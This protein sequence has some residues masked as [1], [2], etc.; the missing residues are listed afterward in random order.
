M[1]DFYD[2]VSA[3]TLCLLSKRA[4]YFLWL[5]SWVRFKIW[6]ILGHALFCVAR[7]LSLDYGADLV[8]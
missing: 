6:F 2:L 7:G 4:K 5:E 3:C 1:V 8:R